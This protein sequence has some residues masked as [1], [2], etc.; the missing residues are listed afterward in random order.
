MGHF[1]LLRPKCGPMADLEKQLD[2]AK[3]IGGAFV[4][5]VVIVYVAV[6]FGDPEVRNPASSGAPPAAIERA[7]PPPG[8]PVVA[9]AVEAPK[10]DGERILEYE[11]PVD[12]LVFARA[13]MGDTT[14]GPSVGALL[15][16]LWLH[17]N[18]KWE[19]F[20]PKRDETSVGKVKKDALSELGRRMCAR[21]R[22]IQIKREPMAGASFFFGNLA[23]EAGNII[24]FV[25]V[26]STGEIVE[27][28][29]ARFCGF[30]AGNYYFENV[31]GGQTQSVQMVGAFDLPENREQG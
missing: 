24:N 2:R 7:V 31:S 10:S 29:R 30:V 17:A 21:G 13:R 9:Q 14:D 26:G 23:T 20:E 3:L 22:V 1:F 18:G 11:N 19:Y 25:A 5:L 4:A 8:Q 12:A 16:A 28:S 15:F 6:K 27:D